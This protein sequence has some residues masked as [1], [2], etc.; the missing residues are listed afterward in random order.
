MLRAPEVQLLRRHV[1]DTADPAVPLRALRVGGWHRDHPHREHRA[2]GGL[3][4]DTCHMHQRATRLAN[5][6]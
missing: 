4:M 3:A 2:H 1:L 5:A 6:I